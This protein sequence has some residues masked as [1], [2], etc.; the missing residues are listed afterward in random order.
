MELKQFRDKMQQYKKAKDSNPQLTYWQ[1]RYAPKYSE[2]TSG[3]EDQET[4]ERPVRYNKNTGKWEYGYNPGA[5]YVKPAFNL[6]DIPVVGDAIQ[7]I[8]AGKSL[9]N[10]DF[11]SAGIAG[12]GLLAVPKSVSKRVIP[13]VERTFAKKYNEAKAF[14]AKKTGLFSDAVEQRNRIIE[15]LQD[16][17]EYW[18]RAK[19][20]KNTYGDDYEQVY[21]EML[22]NYQSMPS[23]YSLPEPTFKNMDN[24]RARMSAKPD[25]I[26]RYMKTGKAAGYEDFEY[27]I[28]PILDEISY[29][30]TRHE[31][32]HY[33]DFNVSKSSNADYGN[34]MFLDMKNDLSKEANPLY[35]SETSYFRTGSEQK[36]YM[37]QLRQFMYDN[38]M[39]N[40]IGDKVT[41]KQIKS[42]INMLPDSEKSTK[43]AYLQFNSPGQYTKWFNKIPLL[44]IPGA[45]MYSGNKEDNSYAEGT[46]GIQKDD[47]MLT[48]NDKIANFQFPEIEIT[49]KSPTGDTWKDRNLYKA[50]KGRQYVNKGREKLSSV[51][52]EVVGF[53]PVGDVMDIYQI[54]KDIY[55]GNYTQAA[56]GAGLFFLPDILAKPIRRGIRKIKNV[57]N[58]SDRLVQLQNNIYAARNNAKD[59]YQQYANNFADIYDNTIRQ[60]TELLKQKYPETIKKSMGRV[61]LE[62]FA[63][64]YNKARHWNDINYPYIIPQEYKDNELYKRLYKDDRSYL[65]FAKDNNLP[66]DEQATVDKWIDKQRRAI[67]GVYSDKPNATIDDLEPMFTEVKSQN[68]GGDRLRTKGGLYISNSIDIADRFSRSFDDDP[69]TAAYAILQLP[70]IDRT[71]PIEQQ[72]SSLRR[73]ILPYDVLNTLL[74]LDPQSLMDQGYIGVQAKYATRSGQLL[75]AYETALFGKPGDKPVKILDVHTSADTKNMHGRWGDYAG[76]TDELYSPRYIGESYGDFIHDAKAYYNMLPEYYRNE[77]RDVPNPI[78]QKRKDEI[79]EELYKQRDVEYDKTVQRVQTLDNRLRRLNSIK[80]F[81]KDNFKSIAI[82]TTIGSGLIGT[83]AGFGIKENSERKDYIRLMEQ[84][85]IDPNLLDDRMFKTYYFTK[86]RDSKKAQNILQKQIKTLKNNSN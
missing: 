23:Y 56:L 57:Y 73:R 54:G 76:A 67:R 62:Q 53:S 45:V 44:G 82:P 61:S 30:I 72:L 37:N 16:N 83:M 33:V 38:N 32:G 74:K 17:A 39:I 69:G 77:I 66:F 75:P 28:D 22:G 41:T 8:E 86:K 63:E 81:D 58:S 71:L 3:V 80:T 26:D 64:S 24:A 27:Q 47:Y 65:Q 40:N 15:E 2:G 36:A 59:A 51:I 85:G 11:V 9:L 7:A 42:A 48:N 34:Q 31:L 78:F 5:G 13:T 35:P 60:E 18:D 25:V 49:A 43:A 12:L 68:E 19:K 84:Q 6:E 79:T 10:K 20:I 29:P 55:E 21:E 70:D 52:P 14:I 1:W 50:Y 46:D 4:S